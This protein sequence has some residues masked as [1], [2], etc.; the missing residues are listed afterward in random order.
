VIIVGRKSKKDS[1][2]YD[3]ILGKPFRLP[4]L[5]LS[6]SKEPLITPNQMEQVV[7]AYQ[8]GLRYTLENPLKERIDALFKH[9][10]LQAE[11]WKSLAMKLAAQHVP[12]FQI[13]RTI[14]I[15]DLADDTVPGFR[16]VGEIRGK[17]RDWTLEKYLRLLNDVREHKESHPGCKY[18]RGAL[19]QLIK[20]K[21]EWKSYGLE[22]LESRLQEA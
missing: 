2:G 22:D 10:D 4:K 11:D 17:N 19:G 7:R 5:I 13:K 16:I 20:Q 9:F 8:S 12:G 1:A 3:G 18:D 14:A 21:L 6:R 15:Y